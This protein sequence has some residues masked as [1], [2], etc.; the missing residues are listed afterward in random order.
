MR[1]PTADLPSSSPHAPTTASYVASSPSFEKNPSQSLQARLTRS[2][3]KDTDL[4]EIDSGSSDTGG[5]EDD[6][7]DDAG[8]QPGHSVSTDGFSF[9]LDTRQ[10]CTQMC[11][12]GLKRWDLLD[13]NCPNVALHHSLEGGSRHRIDASEFVQLVQV[14][15]SE[16]SYRYCYCKPVK[17]KHGIRRQLFKLSLRKHGYTFVGKGTF[18]AAAPSIEH[19]SDAYSRLDSL[20]GHVIP[21]CLGSIDLQTPH[22][23]AMAFTGH[24]L[25]LSWVGDGMADRVYAEDQQEP[26]KRL[27][28]T[29]GVFHNDMRHRNLLWNKECEAV[30]LIDF[31]FA[32][33]RSPAKHKRISRLSG[34][35]KRRPSDIGVSRR[36]A[37][38]SLGL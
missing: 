35:R 32:T 9:N 10:Y 33:M 13:E 7:S 5:D 37:T 8:I 22:P 18:A 6:C 16:Q 2:S 15:M 25:L 27:L 1:E 38:P 30:M 19:E 20:Q 12:L 3:C 17:G 23:L 26:L 14:Q 31:D 28:L 21:V 29:H 24:M 34:K 4:A 11:L 36:K